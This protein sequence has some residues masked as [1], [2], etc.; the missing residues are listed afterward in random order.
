MTTLYRGGFVYTPIDPFANAMVVDDATGT[1]AWI[2]GDDAA[3]GHVDAV[4][5]VVELDGALVT[6]AF[7]DA[8]AHTS[9]TGAT[10]RGVDLAS[11]RSV[12]E[13]LSRIEGAARTGQG[14]PVYAPGWDQGRW[15]EGRPHT[16]AELDRA[17]YGG[18]VYS[19]RVD[20][21]S[22]V[23]SSALAAASGA[24]DL[25]GWEG[26]G[27]VTRDAHH[28]AREAFNGAVTPAQRQ[29][30]IALA[31]QSAAAAGIGLVQE[32][33]GRTLS[34]TDDFAE[35]LATGERGDG[36]QTIGYWAQ[37]VS[38]EAE[39]RDVATLH[40]ARGLAGDLNIDG[41]IGS[42]TAHLRADYADAPG[43]TGN[44]YLTVEQV[45]DHVAACSLAGL[46]AGFHVIGDAG[47]DTAIEGFE[48]AARLVGAATVL[49]G[50]H[51]LE[52]LEMVSR[53][54][55][56]RLVRL[57]VAASVQPA[58]D[59]AWGGT[60]GMYAARL[61]PD[62]VHG[63][64]PMNPFASMLAAGMTVALGSDSPVT[65]FAPWEAVRA[66]VNHHDESQRVSARSAFLAHTRGG[67]RVAG[68]D[69]RG[70]LDLGLPATFAVWEVGDLVVQAPDD[71]I[72]TWS[73]DPRSGTPGLPDLSPGTPAPVCRRTVVRG[74]T[75]FDAGTL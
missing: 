60:H 64:A 41:S 57:G 52:H 3:A 42:R 2:G 69:D 66:C 59:A 49:R 54:G 65:P 67:W 25:P 50:R 40:G 53:E 43:H 27:L 24:R 62:R 13:A 21:H 31:L 20:G 12:V 36:P 48:A 1:I 34:G 37:L 56:E 46:Q 70:Y 74:R 10:L 26:E 29:A 45:R 73:T 63:D 32:N 33:G 61:G 22:A 16:G 23:V 6:P 58:F 72:Q 8:H 55:V 5:E 39:A 35:V 17:S 51:R 28:A 44:A 68:F 18:V 4:D 9:Q 7:V 75:V 38:D 47:V 19:P 15:A 14:R 71:R 11:T 30:D